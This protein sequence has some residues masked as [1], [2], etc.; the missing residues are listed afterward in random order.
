MATN[1]FK[2]MRN[3]PLVVRNLDECYFENG[4]FDYF[5]YEIIRD[6]ME[7]EIAELKNSLLFHTIKVISGYY[8]G[9]Q[10]Y[11]E[12]EHELDL[13]N[14]DNED[15]WY[16]FDMCRSAA[17]RKF[18]AEINKIRRALNKIAK[19]DFYD[20]LCH[21]STFS[22]GCACYVSQKSLDAGKVKNIA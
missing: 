15:C 3:F 16:Y 12:C 4:E 19:K 8:T 2:T 10:F 14:Y 11:V 18:N 7:N 9:L 21:V 1:N 17:Y 22:N 5:L 13:E 6:E 20:V